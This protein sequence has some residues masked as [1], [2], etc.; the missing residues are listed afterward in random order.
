MIKCIE[1]DS[2]FSSNRGLSNHLRGGCRNSRKYEKKCPDCEYIIIYASPSKLKISID[3]NSK[4]QGCCNMGR[5]V[6]IET[7]NKISKKL[8][9]LYDNGEIIANMSGAH[10]EESRKKMAETKSGGIL[11]DSH[12]AK[13]KLGMINSEKHKVAVKNTTRN[14]NISDKAKGRRPSLETRKKMSKNHADISG[15]KNPSKR[16]D[17]KLKLRLKLI[18]RLSENLNSDGKVIIPFFN[19]RACE[20]FDKIMIEKNCKIRH[21]LNGGEFYIKEL[22]YFLDG[23]DAENNIA[24]EWDESHHFICDEYTEKDI[25]RQNEIILLLGCKFIRIKQSDYIE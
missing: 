23:Y 17:V 10:S 16:P 9:K 1:C 11:T 22:G 8:K 25:I 19:K 15:D 7:R 13:I 18:E 21:A 6:S 14:K 24:Y 5:S 3:S 12:K 2:E 20:Y 4:C